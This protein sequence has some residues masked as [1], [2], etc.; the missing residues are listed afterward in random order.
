MRET[1]V[2]VVVLVCLFGQLLGGVQLGTTH[3]AGETL[4]VENA[5]ERQAQ[6]L[7]SKPGGDHTIKKGRKEGGSHPQPPCCRR[8]TWPQGQR[9]QQEWPQHCVT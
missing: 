5:S 3:G 2:V 1:Y 7:G 4:P 8:S 6:S 9:R